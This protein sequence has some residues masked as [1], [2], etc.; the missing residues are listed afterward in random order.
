MPSVNVLTPPIQGRPEWYTGAVGKFDFRVVAEPTQVNVGEPIALTLRVTDLSSGPVNLDYL[1]VPALDRLST[2]TDYFKVPDNPLGGISDGRT[3]TF[4]QTIRPRNADVTEIPPLPMSSF[5]PKTGTYSTIWTKPIPV[6]V[7]DVATVSASDLV[8]G[9]SR[10]KQPTSQTL[11]EIDGGILANYTGDN[12]LESQSTEITP[13]VLAAIALP[14][15]AFVGIAFAL[16]YQKRMH[17]DASKHK[18]AKK[19]ALKTIRTYSQ[20]N[21]DVPIQEFAEALRTLQTDVPNHADLQSLLKRCDAAQFGGYVDA[22]LFE[23]ANKLVETIS[24]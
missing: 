11:T 16:L 18:T 20:A 21:R 7:H 1:A 22:S 23:D 24:C 13:A 15:I 10:T 17:T 9:E 3:K 12:L 4:T 2:L 6:T 19:V 5:D 8:G 14:P